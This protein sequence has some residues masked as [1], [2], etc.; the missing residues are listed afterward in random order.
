MPYGLILA[1]SGWPGWNMVYI[2]H[3]WRKRQNSWK[4]GRKRQI[5]FQLKERVF[6]PR[7]GRGHQASHFYVFLDYPFIIVI[8]FNVRLFSLLKSFVMFLILFF[9]NLSGWSVVNFLPFC[10]IPYDLW[11]IH[12][13]TSIYFASGSFYIYICPCDR[14][15]HFLQYF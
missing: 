2:R 3:I 5:G 11:Y 10:I 15:K 13:H 8:V 7:V 14:E 12:I 1:G 4:T 9:F 6:P